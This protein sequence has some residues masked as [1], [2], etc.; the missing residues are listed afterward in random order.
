MGQHSVLST[1]DVIIMVRFRLMRLINSLYN[2]FFS[3]PRK[4]GRELLDDPVVK[5]IAAKYGKS[6]VQILLKFLVQ[7]NI[8]VIPKSVTPK[9]IKE[10]LELF[11]F[12]LDG[13]DIKALEGLDKGEQGRRAAMAFNQA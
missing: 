6:S 4:V 9:R 12:N 13:D 10:N 8:A 11:D 2:P 5:R 1:M 7:K 3:R